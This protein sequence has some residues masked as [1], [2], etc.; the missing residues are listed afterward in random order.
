[1]IKII[2]KVDKPNTYN[3]CNSD[4]SFLIQGREISLLIFIILLDLPKST[5]SLSLFLSLSLSLYIYIFVHVFIYVCVYLVTPSFS[6][7]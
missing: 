7:R 6:P 1:M 3:G 5:I 2:G 4:I